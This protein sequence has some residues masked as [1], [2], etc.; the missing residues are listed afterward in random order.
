MGDVCDTDFD[1]DGAEDWRDNCPRNGQIRRSDFSNFSRVALD[2][3]GTSQL[4]PEWEVLNN[5]AE[6]F[7][8]HNSDPGLA[9]G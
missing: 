3:E 9:I 7:Q 6:I 4:D 2:P 8:K 5:G 1:G